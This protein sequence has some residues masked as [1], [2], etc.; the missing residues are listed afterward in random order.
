M[1]H[2]VGTSG[3]A[4]LEAGFA[5]VRERFVLGLE[6]REEEFLD[7]LEVLSEPGQTESSVDGI[8]AKAHKL[9]GLAGTVGFARLGSLAAQLESHIDLLQAG[10]R[11]LEVGFVKE[12]LDAVLDEIQIILDDA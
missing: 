7:L 6:D 3:A 11:P 8:R 12:L 4:K 10:P 9:H 5:R 1:E 2:S